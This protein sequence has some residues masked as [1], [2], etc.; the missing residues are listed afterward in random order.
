MTRNIEVGTVVDKVIKTYQQYF[1]V[2]VSIAAVVFLIEAAFRFVGED[3]W[4]LSLIGLVISIILTQLYT[5]TVV[6]VVNDT[7]DGTLDA[8]IGGLVSKVTPVLATLIGAAIVAG[9]GIG[10]GF[11]A[12]II[13]GIIL[14]TL[15]S[16]TAPAI[17]VERLGVFDALGRSWNLVKTNFWQTLGVIFVFWIIALVI[18]WIAALVV[19]GANDVIA[20][21]VIWIVSFLLAP[22]KALASSIL[23]FE[24][25]GVE[26]SAP[27]PP[28]TTPTSTWGA[29]EAP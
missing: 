20:A 16:V 10:I 18:T 19:H 25:R 15:W 13:P 5:G 28:S 27:E 7:R 14:L 11:I 1:A 23:F 24:L 22:L 29:P 4:W 8:S 6:E 2:L 9:I 12:C 17:V 26:S 3:H 21:I